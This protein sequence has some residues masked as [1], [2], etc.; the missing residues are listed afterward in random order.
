[1]SPEVIAALIT[2]GGAILVALMGQLVATVYFAGRLTERVENHADRISTLETAERE[3][4]IRRATSAG[5]T[6]SVVT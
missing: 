5:R 3:D 6:G 4:L 1:M 2:I